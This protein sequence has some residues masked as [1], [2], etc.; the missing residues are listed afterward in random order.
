MNSSVEEAKTSFIKWW[1]IQSGT[2]LLCTGFLVVEKPVPMGLIYEL[3]VGALGVLT[4]MCGYKML[5]CKK[6][7]LVVFYQLYALLCTSLCISL[8][9]VVMMPAFKAFAHRA[10]HSMVA[11]H[12]VMATFVSM[13]YGC[14]SAKATTCA[15]TY[16]EAAVPL[17][18][19]SE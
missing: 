12:Y 4:G 14:I 9:Y 5:D 15:N 13:M 19:K 18:K 16:G 17:K 2:A 10:E 8:L 11:D 7:E 3:L 6:N 1:K